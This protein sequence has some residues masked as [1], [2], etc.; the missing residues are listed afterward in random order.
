MGK[1]YTYNNNLIDTSILYTLPTDNFNNLFK[2]NPTFLKGGQDIITFK[3]EDNDNN[4]SNPNGTVTINI[5]NPTKIFLPNPDSGT[6]EIRILN[7]QQKTFDLSGTDVLNRTLSY[8]IVTP[9][10]YGTAVVNNNTIIYDSCNNSTTETDSIQVRT[11]AE[12]NYSDILSIQFNLYYKS[13]T[14]NTSEEIINNNGKIINISVV[15]VNNSIDNLVF[16]IT[17]ISN[18]LGEFYNV[19]NDI[20]TNKFDITSLAQGFVLSTNKFYF[21]PNNNIIGDSVVTYTVTVH[22]D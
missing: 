6:N 7:Y 13:I 22:K 20:S 17:D 15:P 14:T 9:P 18:V 19:V 5:E 3:I 12:D 8:S 1:L 11:L 16:K 2:Y 21:E 10:T 4:V